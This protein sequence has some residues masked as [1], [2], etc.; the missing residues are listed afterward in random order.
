MKNYYV[1]NIIWSLDEG[2]PEC[3]NLPSECL[4]EAEDEYYVADALSDKYGFCV[5]TLDAEE[6][7]IKLIK[8]FVNHNRLHFDFS[9]ESDFDPETE[10]PLNMIEEM[11]SISDD[12]DLRA[13]FFGKKYD[14]SYVM[15]ATDCDFLIFKGKNFKI[16]GDM[17]FLI[18][19]ISYNRNEMCRITIS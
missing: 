14:N 8:G 15:T 2:D 17:S 4:I 6:L 19:D 9:K 3:F 18:K 11:F 1:S 10:D 12:A 7:T 5:E 13:E 16:D